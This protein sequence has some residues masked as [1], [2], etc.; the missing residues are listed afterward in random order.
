MKYSF[1]RICRLWRSAAKMYSLVILEMAVGTA[2]LV[3]CLNMVFS[4]QD[5]LAQ[6]KADMAKNRVTI[7]WHGTA[8]D[9]PWTAIKETAETTEEGYIRIYEG[10]EGWDYKDPFPIGYEDYETVL[11]EFGQDLMFYY[12]AFQRSDFWKDDSPENS[13]VIW[14]MF[15]NDELFADTFSFQ[16]EKDKIYVGTEVMDIYSEMENEHREWADSF[17]YPAADGKI[18][19]SSDFGAQYVPVPAKSAPEYME[20][21]S[22][23]SPYLPEED[24]IAS[25]RIPLENAVILPVEMLPYGQ[26]SSLL[27]PYN[28]LM[29]SYKDASS[30]NNQ[31]PELLSRLGQLRPGISFEINDEYLQAEK[32]IAG[33][34]NMIVMLTGASATVM[35]I[36]FVS[37]TGI[38]LVLLARRRKSIA[39]TYCCGA[40]GLKS[41][42]ELAAEAALV[43]IAGGV[44]GLAGAFAA[45]PI[46]REKL[47][48]IDFYLENIAVILAA[49]IAAAL[50]SCLI[51]LAGVKLREPAR[52][53]KAL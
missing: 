26:L 44:L 12:G 40:T 38:L 30:V 11:N 15:L 52:E 5:R 4:N 22:Y 28:T 24:Y 46:L 3:T 17:K 35:I 48:R 10:Q 20:L 7:T 31:A 50:V 47:Y 37:M 36:V 23:K 27:T 21:V 19:L 32:S 8:E 53:L 49:A 1:Y 6:S 45:V 34:Q 14:Y 9:D 43:F 51:A 13:T 33:Q 41:F 18:W 25:F 39:V 42:W 29:D 2:L 16:R